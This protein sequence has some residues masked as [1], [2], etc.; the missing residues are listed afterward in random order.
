MLLRVVAVTVIG[1]IVETTVK[2]TLPLAGRD[3]PSMRIS[4]LQRERRCGEAVSSAEVMARA[5]IR[6]VQDSPK[7]VEADR[8]QTLPIGS[9]GQQAAVGQG[10]QPSHQDVPQLGGS[11]TPQPPIL[12]TAS[13]PDTRTVGAPCP[14]D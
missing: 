10:V 4:W 14:A 2:G 9:T 12:P 1:R 7:V 8:Q 5:A 11:A 3:T 6:V 13:P